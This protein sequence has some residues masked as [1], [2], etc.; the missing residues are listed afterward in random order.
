MEGR[1]WRLVEIE[2]DVSATE[3]MEVRWCTVRMTKT[4]AQEE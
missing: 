4:D 3:P 2:E 1:H